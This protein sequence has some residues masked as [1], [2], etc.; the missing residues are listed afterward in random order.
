MINKKLLTKTYSAYLFDMDGTLVNSEKFKGLALSKA[1][2]E[3]GG[4]VDVNK[5]KFIMGESW[6]VVTKYIF[7]TAGISPDLN[8]FNNEFGKIYKDLL[9]QNLALNPN[10]RN[11][12]DK[13]KTAGKKIGVVSSAPRW[14]LDQILTQLELLPYF[15]LIISQ[16]DV[17]HHKPHP[18]AY[19]SALQKLSLPSSE[20]LIFEDS[21]AGI[22][23][24]IKANCDVV[25]FEHEFNINNDLSLAIKV[26]SDFK[27]VIL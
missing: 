20:V 11:L 9:S 2:S 26:I 14:T 12:L 16:E 5:Y 1:C 25:A 4:N 8:A 23:A 13:I 15:D 6:L 24:A 3:F 22:N 17:V 18:E 10:V 7:E 27:E 19:L 21:N